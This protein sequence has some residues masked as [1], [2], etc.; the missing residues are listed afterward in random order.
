MAG[1][2]IISAISDSRSL[3]PIVQTEMG[4]GRVSDTMTNEAEMWLANQRGIKVPPTPTL[5]K[6]PT[7]S[8]KSTFV[9]K[10]LAG[11][12][13]RYNRM[14]LL[15]T[16]RKALCLQQ[17]IIGNANSGLPR[18]GTSALSGNP[19]WD[20]IDIITYQEAISYI[21]HDWYGTLNQ[22]GV[23]VC[24]EAHF[25]CSDATFNAHTS[26]ILQMLIQRFFWIQRVYM[27]ATPEIVIQVIRFQEK[28]Q[29][30]MY[31]SQCLQQAYNNHNSLLNQHEEQ[32][33]LYRDSSETMQALVEK[34]KQELQASKANLDAEKNKSEYIIQ[35]GFLKV[36][37][38]ADC[39]PPLRLHFFH[40]W[41]S[42]VNNIKSSETRDK[43]LIFVKT[44]E[45]GEALK[46]SLGSCADFFNADSKGDDRKALHDMIRREY[47][48]KN[49]LIATTILYNGVNFN[50][51]ALKHI[52]VDTISKLELIQML[53][54][55]RFNRDRDEAINLYVMVPKEK[56]LSTYLGLTRSK[57]QLTRSYQRDPFG[58]FR[59]NWENGKIDDDI[60]KLFGVPNDFLGTSISMSLYAPYELGL[61][62]NMYETCL[63]LIKRGGHGFEEQICSWLHQTYAEE[64]KYDE[65]LEALKERIKPELIACF[66]KYKNLSPFP[67]EK[68][69]DFWQELEKILS[70]HI[71]SLDLKLRGGSEQSRWKADINNII[72]CFNLAYVLPNPKDK[73][74][75]LIDKKQEKKDSSDTE[76]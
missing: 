24:D 42:I 45:N 55:K 57:L 10:D 58:F 32:R 71:K 61:E 46:K 29:L 17:R 39:F 8:G 18:L 3:L 64:M 65:D 33:N 44:K 5:I 19:I 67:S 26:E 41:K 43:W 13:K 51:A 1:W 25:F 56:D 35:S 52:V 62:E 6:A 28:Q 63:D 15:L 60:Q 59:D 53:G 23:V 30:H 40:E 48:E 76:A 12:A 2:D 47:F 37:N 9:M 70:P 16:N 72:S 14:V 54:R 68:I 22:V 31:T 74:L 75:T 20:N 50:D 4:T 36:H 27:T 21:T 7:G 66:E 49:V 69:V 73:M 34:Q 38:Y 11:I